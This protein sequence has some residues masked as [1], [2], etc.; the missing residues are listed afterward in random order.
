MDKDES[1]GDFSNERNKVKNQRHNYT[2]K[3]IRIVLTKYKE[4]NSVTETGKLFNIPRTTVSGWVQ[5]QESYFS[6]VNNL[7]SL[8]HK[9]V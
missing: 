3:E 5:K 4:N 8:K 7:S 9:Q 6:K 1:R 2:I